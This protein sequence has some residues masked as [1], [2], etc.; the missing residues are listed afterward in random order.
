MFFY[1]C[2]HEET[3][4]VLTSSLTASL[5]STGRCYVGCLEK[6]AI[7]SLTHLRMPRVNYL[8]SWPTGAA[9]A[10]MLWG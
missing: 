2:K 9:V 3:N 6:K 10:Q 5:H 8:A 1:G 7:V 4:L